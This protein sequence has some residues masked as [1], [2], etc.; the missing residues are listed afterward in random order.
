MADEKP[1]PGAPLVNASP[2][3]AGPDKPLPEEARRDPRL[4]QDERLATALGVTMNVCARLAVKHGVT[5]ARFV[6]VARFLYRAQ[7]ADPALRKPAAA[8]PR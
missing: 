2:L 3:V 4:E 7:R 8:K 1:N 6:E 5:E